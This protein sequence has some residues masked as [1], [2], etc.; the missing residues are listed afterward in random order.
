MKKLNLRLFRMIK[1]SKGQNIAILIVVITGLFTYTAMNSAITNLETS[2]L[3]FYDLTNFG[4]VYVQMMHFPESEVHNLENLDN[5]KDVDARIVFD[6]PMITDNRDEKVS[7]RIVTVDKYEN[8]I[9]KLFVEKGSRAI[10]DREVLVQ[11]QFAEARNIDVGDTII[12]QING[13]RYPLLIKGLVSSPEFTYVMEDEQ[14]LMPRPD[15]FGIIFLEKNFVGLITGMKGIYNDLV[16]TLEDDSKY[17]ETEKLFKNRFDKYGIIRIIEKEDQLSN[18]VMFEEINGVK[19]ISGFIPIVFLFV[20]AAILSAMIS[21]NVKNDRLVIGILKAL[22]YSNGQVLR[23]YTMYAVS[24][25]SVGGVVGILTGTLM[26]GVMTRMYLEFFYIPLLKVKVDP[27]N[28][29]SAIVLTTVFCTLAGLYGA[30]RVLK[31]SPAESM[32][33][34][35]PKEGNRIL[36]EK[37]PSIWRKVSFTWKIVFRNI[38]RDKKKFIFI[39]LGAAFTVAMSLMTFWLSDLMGGMFTDHYGNFMKMDYSIQFSQPLSRNAI[40]DLEKIIK[41]DHIEGKIEMPFEISNGRL[42]KAVNVIG[43][44]RNTRFF[45]FKDYMG[46]EVELPKT[47]ALLSYNLAKA[48]EVDVGDVVLINNYIPGRNDVYVE[49]KGVIKQIL[50]INVYMDI[51]YMEILTGKGSYNGAYINTDKNIGED[52]NSLKNI[53][54]VQ[55]I[56]E[57]QDAFMEYLDL[58]ILAVVFMVIFSGLLGFVIIYSM[59]ILSINERSMEFSSLRVLGFTKAEIF[60]IILKENTVMSALGFIYGLP[61]GKMLIDALRTVYVSDLYTFDAPINIKNVLYAYI[62]TIICLTIAQLITYKKI[63][64]LNFIEA[65][66]SRT[67]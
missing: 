51:S 30:R 50:G 54:G 20:A 63:R 48:L 9:N 46:N 17:E 55:S 35:V 14:A 16:L 7:V 8:R 60:G 42:T 26:S 62:F 1:H 44:E 56:G 40:I 23:H 10:G 21:R 38:F 25:G 11:K 66:K 3:E 41:P 39:S 19:Q 49:V 31:I 53:S 34:E 29:L 13:V 45:D 5:V 67:S 28:I 36:L 18:S 6:A 58:T 64:T 61:M 12:V 24:I 43:L 33:P 65:L 15:K 52:L 59:T 32:R 4:D 57:M 37:V 27:M 47:G 22:G 2:L